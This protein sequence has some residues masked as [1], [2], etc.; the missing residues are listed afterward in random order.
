[1][2]NQHFRRSTAIPVHISPEAMD[3]KDM[4]TIAQASSQSRYS[5]SLYIPKL[6]LCLC[7]CPSTEAGGKATR[8]TLTMPEAIRLPGYSANYVSY[9]STALATKTIAGISVPSSPLI[10]TALQ[11]ARSYLDTSMY[12]HVVRVWILSVAIAERIS[13]LANR[14][15][16]LHSVAAILHDMASAKDDSIKHQDKAYEIN[17]ANAVRVFIDQHANSAEWSQSR[18][19]LLWNAVALQASQKQPEVIAIV[20]G[21]LAEYGGPNLVPGNVLTASE[22]QRIGREF[23][24]SGL[25]DSAVQRLCSQSLRFGDFWDH[26]WNNHLR[27]RPLHVCPVRSAGIDT[28]S[29]PR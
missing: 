18:K 26:L 29:F 19:Q 5:P 20:L 23:P 22:W 7:N 16:E 28:R 9:M 17:C 2:D 12:N 21:V 4:K 25:R 6:R 3:L 27:V 11:Y 13:S 8:A 10:D 24:R 1:M 15:K 14:D